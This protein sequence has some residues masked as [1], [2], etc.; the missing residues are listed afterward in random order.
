VVNPTPRLFY[1]RER[2]GTRCIEGWVC[3]RDGLD[4]RGK[5][6]RYRDSIH[7]PSSSIIPTVFPACLLIHCC[8][9]MRL[10]FKSSI[11]TSAVFTFGAC[12]LLALLT[13][14]LLYRLVTGR[15][16]A[17]TVFVHFMFGCNSLPVGHG[18]LLYEFPRSHNDAPQSVGL[19]W[20]S[21]QLVSYTSA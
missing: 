4:C 13:D 21:D 16:A 20:T 5:S 12:A 8:L 19:L 6:R 7:G 18:P 11:E 2:P 3:P 17:L 1:P 15:P 10:T 9:I 14:T